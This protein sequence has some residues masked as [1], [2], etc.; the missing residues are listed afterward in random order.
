MM[1]TVSLYFSVFFNEMHFE[2]CGIF[3]NNILLCS[4]RVSFITIFDCCLNIYISFEMLDQKALEYFRN[5]YP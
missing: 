2:R 5:M 3:S 4:T 1:T